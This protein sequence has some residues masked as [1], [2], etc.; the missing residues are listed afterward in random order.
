[1]ENEHN[2]IPASGGVHAQVDQER[3]RAE[4]R[5]QRGPVRLDLPVALV[6]G[7]LLDRPLNAAHRVM[8]LPELVH[9]PG[10]VIAFAQT[11]AGVDVQRGPAAGLGDV[12]LTWAPLAPSGAFVFAQL[13]APTGMR[14]QYVSVGAWRAGLGVGMVQPDWTAELGVT[15]PLNAASTTLAFLEP[16]PS[17]H[18]HLT[19]SWG[20][21]QVQAQ[22]R[23][24][25]LGRAGWYS[26]VTGA[27]TFRWAGWSFEEDLPGPGADVALSWTGCL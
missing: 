27:L 18:A 19:R 3:L 14:A 5:V 9:E 6:W 7:G 17:V 24:S 23:S 21:W 26:G 20:A 10:G 22:A 11:D 12:T 15:V 4:L 13:A 1:M 2:I 25:P 16:R 8:G